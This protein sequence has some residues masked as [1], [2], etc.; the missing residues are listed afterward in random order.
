MRIFLEFDK[1]IILLDELFKK[2]LYNICDK[3]LLVKDLK[4]AI[5]N[6]FIEV[7]LLVKLIKLT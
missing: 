7:F 5:C 6:Q 1:S 2:C 4:K 3:Q